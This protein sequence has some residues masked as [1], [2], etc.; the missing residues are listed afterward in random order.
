[1]ELLLGVAWIG[2][3][4]VT[5]IIIIISSYTIVYP[6]ESYRICKTLFEHKEEKNENDE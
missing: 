3:V 2:A 1:M 5:L 6:E 4:I